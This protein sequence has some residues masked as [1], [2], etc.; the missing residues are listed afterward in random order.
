PC[1]CG[2]GV[3]SSPRAAC[4]YGC[5][6]RPGRAR[7][8]AT[9]I[10]AVAGPCLH[11]GLRC[12]NPPVPRSAAPPPAA[13]TRRTLLG[14]AGVAALLPLVGCGRIALGGPEEY[15]PPP[16][17]IDDLY[18]TDLLELLERA[19]AGTEHMVGVGAGDGD[20]EVSSTLAALSSALP[21][22]RTALLTGA[23]AEDERAA[24]Q[25]PA[26]GQAS[27]PPTQ[28]VPA[29]LA[30]LVAVLVRLRDLGAS[31]ARQVSGSLARPVVAI[32][33]HTARAA[34]RLDG[35]PSWRS[36]TRDTS[37]RCS[38]PGP[39]GRRGS[40]TWTSPHCTG[41]GPRSSGRSPSRT[42][43]PSWPARRSTRSPA[44]PSTS[45]PPPGCRRCWPRGCSS[46]TSR[47]SEPP[48]SSADRCRSRR[49]SRRR[50]GWGRWWTGW[51]RCRASR[52][53][54]RLPRRSDGPARRSRAGAGSGAADRGDHRADD[55]PPPALAD[56][57]A[58]A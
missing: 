42:A 56:P 13:P 20:P 3:R 31:A 35:G 43:R 34:R 5:L 18:R 4:C 21:V 54:S 8:D 6:G 40:S 7:A 23:E 45:S 16:P 36:G 39:R 12:E 22:Q 46:T 41:S 11:R 25:D 33:A 53:S 9:R 30:E 50:S 38:P 15:T 29:D 47:S 44:G 55:L 58:G 1:V 17:G 26:P 10:V 48:P 52:S 37:T 51:S 24:E 2:P 57:A 32:A 28:D 14:A 19:L 49:R 27:P